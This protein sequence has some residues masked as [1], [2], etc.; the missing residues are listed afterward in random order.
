MVFICMCVFIENKHKCTRVP[1]QGLTAPGP[2]GLQSS[3]QQVYLSVFPCN[4]CSQNPLV[5]VA[6]GVL[7]GNITN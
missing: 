1:Q 2:Q 3:L 6:V 4:T 5:I 7:A